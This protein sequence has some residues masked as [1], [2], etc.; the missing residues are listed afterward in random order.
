MNFHFG[1]DMLLTNGLNLLAD[2]PADFWFPEQAST[3]AK[4]V[5]SFYYFILWLCIVFFALIVGGMVYF[6]FK[7]RE[8]P[9]YKG[10]PEALHNNFLEI[11]WTVIPTLIVIYVFVRGTFGYL[12]MASIP[13]NTIDIDV[14]AQKWAWSF[15]YDNQAESPVLYLPVGEKI[16]L[17]MRS[18]DVI[19]SLFV[20]AFRAKADVVPGRYT[21]MWFQ[22][23]KTGT[24]DL[25]CTEYCGD[26][27]SRMITKVEVLPLE[28]F[29]AWKAKA[30]QAPEG[31]PELGEWLY[32]RRCK[33][34]HSND[35]TK[36]V[37]PSF[38]G[39]WGK[40]VKLGKS[41][42]GSKTVEFDQNYVRQ[43]ILY[44]QK[45]ARDGY[46]SGTQMNSFEGQLNDDQIDGI[47]DYLKTLK[48]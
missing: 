14:K 4:E 45:K 5:D 26:K 18:D 41:D 2:R 8:R 44:P 34:C 48:D 19:H 47:I 46:Q 32:V 43:S 31:G 17:T 39:S 12:E 28:E 24:F 13:K 36:V 25:F 27:H 6:I 22:P 10:S 35:G 30:A 42:D 11:S 16:K 29:N 9:G 21:P 1:K 7:Y 40:E 38:K 3:F 33:S 15:K 23:T 37:G 20:P